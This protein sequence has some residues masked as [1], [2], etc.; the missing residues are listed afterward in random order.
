MVSKRCGCASDSCGCVVTGGIGVTVSGTGS[1]TNPYILDANLAPSS[2][3]VQDENTVVRSGVTVIDFQ[4]GGVTTTPGDAGEV[5]VTV[6]SPPAVPAM[7]AGVASIPIPS[8]LN[9]PTSVAVTFPVGRFT[10]APIVVATI[11][12]STTPS[13]R[14]PINTSG[15]TPTGVTLWVTQLSGTLAATSVH[16]FAVVAG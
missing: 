13:I 4:G 2:L 14:S 10:V 11:Y 5:I 3:N 9:T 8:A 16:W 15:V 12:G 6:P 1:K 7:A